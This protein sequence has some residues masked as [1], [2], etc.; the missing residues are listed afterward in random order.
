MMVHGLISQVCCVRQHHC[1]LP[2]ELRWEE[3]A[4]LKNWID[5]AGWP[6]PVADAQCKALSI[7]PGIP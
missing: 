3:V 7:M 1:M 5:T 4:P 6:E 2:R